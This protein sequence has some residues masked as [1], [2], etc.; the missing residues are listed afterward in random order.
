MQSL[1]PKYGEMGDRIPISRFG[2]SPKFL[3]SML[4]QFKL[5]DKPLDHIC[6]KAAEMKVKSFM[7][8]PTAGEYIEES[9]SLD[10]AIHQLIM[11]HHQSLLVT[12]KDQI[13]GILRLTDVFKHVCQRLK[14][15]SL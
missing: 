9:T 5:F 12:R 8:T 13:V 6:R 2:F 3:A 7:S 1:E 10:L 15:C 4:E 11:G 14:S